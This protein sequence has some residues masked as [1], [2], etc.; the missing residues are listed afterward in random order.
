MQYPTH[1]ILDLN[2][3]Q[4]LLKK[5]NWQQTYIQKINYKIPNYF[6]LYFFD[7]KLNSNTFLKKKFDKKFFFIQG[8]KTNKS[9]MLILSNQS[10]S[11]L[12]LNF[13]RKER[14]YTKLKYSRCP[15]YDFVSGGWAALFAGLAGFLISEKF[16]IELVDSGDFYITLM[17][18]IFFIFSVR[19]LLRILDKDSKASKFFLVWDLLLFLQNIFLLLIKFF[20]RTRL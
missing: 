9:R 10:F 2:F 15:Q 13:L 14:L 20:N 3:S 6:S 5:L 11:L 7:K 19:P 17:Y 18:L 8:N 1:L 16:G 12:N 4:R